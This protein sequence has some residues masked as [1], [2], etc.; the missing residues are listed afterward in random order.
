MEGIAQPFC[1][2]CEREA[3]KE[4]QGDSQEEQAREW[5]GDSK[6]EPE[7]EEGAEARSGS[8]RSG[9]RKERKMVLIL[10]ML[11]RLCNFV[12]F[13]RESYNIDNG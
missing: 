3:R 1:S 5:Q 12:E 8:E 7:A 9:G 6:E 10:R 2:R 4:R 11:G 13:T